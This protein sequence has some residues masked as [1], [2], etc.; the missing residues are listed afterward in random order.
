[1]SR[2]FPGLS[3]TDANSAWVGFAGLE[4]L[5]IMQVPF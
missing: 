2:A 3:D 5:Y 4:A 1:M